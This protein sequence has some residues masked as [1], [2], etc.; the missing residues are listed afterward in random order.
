MGTV[1]THTLI[2]AISLSVVVADSAPAAVDPDAR[3]S[4]GASNLISNHLNTTNATGLFYPYDIVVDPSVAHTRV[5]V[6]DTF[7]SRVIA[8]ECAGAS[9]DLPTEATAVRVFGQLDF[10]QGL[11]NHGHTGVVG[12]MTMSFPRGVAVASDGTLYVADTGNHRV[13]RFS[14]PWNDPT[15][16]VALGQV[17]LGTGVAG[18]SSAGLNSPEG[19][20]VDSGGSVWVADTANHRV[21]KFSSVVTGAAS[22]LQIGGPGAASTTT[23][24]SPTDVAFDSSGRLFVADKGFSRVLTYATP[25]VGGKAASIVFGQGGSFSSGVANKNG[26]SASSL[27]FPE[28]L[29]LDSSNRLWVGDSANNRVLEFDTPVSSQTAARVFGQAD[30]DQTPTFSTNIHDAPDGFP[31]A[32]GVW[33]ARGIARDASGTLLVCDR[34]NSRVL[35]FEDP[36]GAV[37]GA[38]TA[39]RVLGKD[40]FI[41]AFANEPSDDRMNNPTGVAV[42]SSVSPARLWVVDIG[43]NRLLGYASTDALATGQ[44]ADLVLG[45]AGFA[46][47]HTNAALNSPLQDGADAVANASS[48]FFAEGVAVDGVGAVYV[49]DTSNSR[50]LRFDDPFANDGTA[51]GV[52]GQDDFS[53]RNPHWPWG[54]AESLAGPRG[55]DVD[56]SGDVWV[57]DTLDHRVVRFA[58]G[59]SSANL[60]LGQSTFVSLSVFPP[61]SSGCSATQMKSPGNVH[62]AASGRVYVADTFNHRVLVFSPPFSNGMSATT[63][64]GQSNYTSCAANR[65]GSVGALTLNEPM[66][67]YEDGAGNVY[68]TDSGNSRTLVFHTPFGS[69]DLVP[70]EVLGQPDFTTNTVT[71]PD[72]DTQANPAGLDMDPSGR[73]FIA[74]RENSRVTWFDSNG[75]NAIGLDPSPVPMVAGQFFFLTGSSFTPGS[76]VKLFVATASGPEDFGAYVPNFITPGLLWFFVPPEVTLGNGFVTAVVINTDEGFIQS[77]SQS[78]L[79]FGDPTR[80]MPTVLAIDGIPL[81]AVDPTIPTANIETVISQGSTI[82]I[83]GTGFNGPLV[84]LFTAVG[85]VGP[86][87]PLA[88]GTDTSFQIEIPA[89]TVTGPGSF[90]VVNNPYTGTVI[91]NAVSVPIGQAL[92]ITSISQDGTTIAVDGAGFSALSVI[93]FFAQTGGGVENFGGLDGGGASNIPLT[94]V[95]EN[96]FTFQVPAGAQGGAA[97]VMVL[98]PPFIPFSSTTGDEDGGFTLN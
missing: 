69:G 91:S 37:P 66:G 15:A 76:Q 50:I 40:L 68:I 41:G 86:L 27:A 51:D 28:K 45:Q 77:P 71:P 35:Q 79:L 47:G 3:I 65:G 54:A 43:N 29:L 85:N 93:N 83:E 2:L 98:N 94:I 5:Y 44:P 26:L 62:A 18:S 7:N 10:S 84:N 64:F 60:V 58:S 11:R 55:V 75:G 70:D 39:D 33:G 73:L 20:A 92:D 67:I 17:S 59:A 14:D 89:G 8:F 42:D 4:I 53:D 36:T 49:A 57:A 63:I 12:S 24:S 23:L 31:S 88:G 22:S 21:L 46:E 52:L 34:D 25:L 61:Y 87:S 78:Q 32:A 81:T 95:S 82:W 1:I 9:C 90:Q 48:L 56:G 80:N 6:A 96:Q 16:D 72:A 97:Y 74:D 19:V 30:R 13:L 38:V